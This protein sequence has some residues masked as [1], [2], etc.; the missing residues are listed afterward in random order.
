M[1]QQLSVLSANDQKALDYF[2]R[3]SREILKGR[4][5]DMYLYGSKARGEATPESDMDV[6]LVLSGPVEKIKTIDLLSDLILDILLEYKVLIAV[7]PASLQEFRQKQDRLLF[8]TVKK[9]GIR[10]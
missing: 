1:A 10:L 8:R 4:I 2:S 9:E 5:T 6:M 7:F 3:K